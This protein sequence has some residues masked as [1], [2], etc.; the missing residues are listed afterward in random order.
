ML[1]LGVVTASTRPG[2]I[3]PS[4]AAWVAEEARAH[5]KFEVSEVDIADFDLPVYDEPK[6]PRMQDYQNAHTQK[7]AAAIDAAD[8]FVFVTPE[9]NY[10]PTPALLNAFT[11]L[12]KE[13]GRKVCAF[14]SYGG[15]SGGIRGVQAIKPIFATA[16]M[17]C[18]AQQVTI[19]FVFGQLEEGSFTPSD[20]NKEA[21]GPMLDELAAW[22]G[23]LKSIR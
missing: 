4:I 1:R 20:P 6:H 16:N 7:W 17:M 15:V 18:L 21:V 3:G 12:A 9:Y 13:W 23:A 10:G 19:P 8:A 2:R 14:A 5:G 11:Y 22:A